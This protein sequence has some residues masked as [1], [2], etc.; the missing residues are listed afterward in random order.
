V[1]PII[2][3]CQNAKSIE[4]HDSRAVVIVDQIRSGRWREQ[5]EH[6][7]SVC[8]GAVEAGRSGKE[9]AG[10]LKLRL[11]AVMWSGCFTSRAA[12]IAL[13]EKLTA[14]SGLLCADLDDLSIEQLDDCRAKLTADPHVWALFTSPT[15]TGLKVVFRVPASAEQHEASFRAVQAVVRKSCAVEI[16]QACS[17]VP[18]L[19]FVSYD[20]EAFSNRN[21]TELPVESLPVKANATKAVALVVFIERQRIVCALL[22]E[23]S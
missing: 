9:A 17:D 19:C 6:I 1:N 2:S 3:Q 5:V 14:H 15:G 16:D 20:P 10:E 7:L 4:T 8:H 12:G 23:V 18:R 21:A 22:G 13:S 11:P